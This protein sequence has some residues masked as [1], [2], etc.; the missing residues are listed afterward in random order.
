MVTD[1]AA[2]APRIQSRSQWTRSWSANYPSQQRCC[3]FFYIQSDPISRFIISPSYS[4]SSIKIKKTGT[5]RIRIG[6]HVLTGSLVPLKNPI[7][8]MRKVYDPVCPPPSDSGK[9]HVVA[10]SSL[11]L[12]L[13]SQAPIQGPVRYEVAGVARRKVCWVG[14][15]VKGTVCWHVRIVIS[16]HRFCFVCISSFSQVDRRSSPKRKPL[17]KHIQP[18]LTNDE[19]IPAATPSFSKGHIAHLCHGQYAL[20]LGADGRVLRSL[21]QSGSRRAQAAT[22]FDNSSDINPLHLS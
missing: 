10:D 14:K 12:S 22:S 11:T 18:R 15:Q 2:R 1:R 9:P 19:T 3:P 21:T 17:P 4:S 6:N 8:I 20:V 5:A 7:A 13:D 16:L